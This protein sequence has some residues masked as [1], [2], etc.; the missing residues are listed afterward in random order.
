[1]VRNRQNPAKTTDVVINDF[2]NEWITCYPF[3][4]E[5]VVDGGVE[6]IGKFR[7]ALNDKYG[8]NVK[9]ITTRNP[10]A[11]LMVER[12]HQSIKNMI[13]SQNIE[14]KANLED[15]SWKGVLNAVRFAMQATL[16]TTMRATPMQLVYGCDAIH[17]IHFEANW[18]YIK[19]RQRQ[20]I[21]QNNERENACRVPHTYNVGDQVMVEQP[22]HRKYGQPKYKGPFTVDRVQ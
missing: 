21:C 17:N 15:G 12:M 14:S 3:P 1:M 8:A 4:V 16:H 10:Q 22:Q 6:F 7:Q 20:V 13:C 19:H 18:Q 2:E 11:N 9:L 5:I